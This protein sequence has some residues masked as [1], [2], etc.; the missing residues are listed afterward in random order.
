[1]K[2]KQV[3]WMAFAMIL[4][5]AY[6][7]FSLAQSQGGDSDEVIA[8]A[9]TQ[10][11]E[12]A[13]EIEEIVVTGSRLR[14]SSFTS[15]S[16]LQVISGNISR[17]AG[18]IDATS[19]LQETSAAAGQQTDLTFSRFVQDDGPG[20]TSLSLRG[21][22]AARTLILVNGRRIAPAGVE[23]A[24]VNPNLNFIP[25]TLISR[26]ELLLDG[27]SSVYGSDAV[28]GVTNAILRK[29]F[30]GFDV[31]IIHRENDHSAGP[32]TGLTLSWGQDW[33]RGFVGVGFE[34][35]EGAATTLDDVPWTRGCDRHHEITESGEIRT[36][37]LWWL[38]VFNMDVG[39][40]KVGALAGYVTANDGG[41]SLFYTPGYT[42]GGWGDFSDWHIR[43]GVSDGNG[44][45]MA[46]VNFR[47]YNLNGRTQHSN[48]S[49]DYDR[50]SFMAY[51]EYTFEGDTNLTLYSEL[52]YGQ[53]SSTFVLGYVQ[54]FPDV[55][56]NNPYN[57]CNPGATTG[58]G[59][60]CVQ[61]VV[62]SLEN[63]HV[64]R[65]LRPLLGG[66]DLTTTN[67]RG[68]KPTPTGDAM[69][70]TPV[71]VVRGDRETNETEVDQLRLVGGVRMDLPFM[72]VGSLSDWQLDVSFAY[73]QSSGESQRQ[74]IRSDRLDLALGTYST[75][76]TPCENNRTNDD[77]TPMHVL[78][79]DTAPGCVD[80]NMFAPS[81][82]ATIPGD[83]ATEAE[84]NYLLDIRDFDTEYTQIVFQT[85]ANGTL[86][87][88]PG[89]E[90]IGGIG[91]EWRNDD[92][93]SMP[94]HVARDGLIFGYFK[95]GGADGDKDTT[96]AYAEIELPLLGSRPL[97]E[98]LTLNASVRWTD[99][100]LYGDGTTYA[101]KL[102]YRPVSSLL[103]RGTTGTSF[104]APNLREV[105][106]RDQTGF[107]NLLDPCLIPSVALD[108]IT[109]DYI[110]ANDNRE[111]HV[112]ANCRANGVDPTRALNVGTSNVYSV[113]VAARGATNLDAEES[114]AYSVGFAWEQ[115]FTTAFD[116]ALGATYYN[117]EIENTIIEP[118]A[119]FLIFDCYGSLTGNSPFC[120]LITRDEDPVRPYLNLVRRDFLNRDEEKVSG[121]D[122][123][124]A[125]DDTWTIYG[126]P[127][128]I[129]IELN[130][131]H[132][133]GRSTLFTDDEGNPDFNQFAGEWGY[134]DWRGNM[135][136][137]ASWDN[138]Q[139]FWR[140]N[141]LSGMH[142]DPAGE[143]AFARVGTGGDTCL[144]PPNDEL[145]RDYSRSS[146]YFRHTASVTWQ[147]DDW[148]VRFGMDNVFDEGPPKVDS[149]EPPF[150]INGAVIGL[151]DVFGRTYFLDVQYK[152]GGTQ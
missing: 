15:I 54:L 122:V 22:G 26:Y 121:I 136:I 60:D 2:I 104:R 95:D 14:R 44:D 66:C 29:D 113:E 8:E 12:A 5:L 129:G 46:D 96:E 98:E 30:D 39:D 59:V 147:K 123:N 106:L 20:A 144:G 67:C 146:D 51:G 141:Y 43:S 120:G 64:A 133:K 35:R 27:A 57:L 25:G 137:R 47:D 126:R 10:Q 18:L 94:D 79:A 150:E 130:A 101:A 119:Q 48:L 37:D 36:R 84:S 78:A 4:G 108:D 56:A 72:N 111:A 97:A 49:P 6:T 142:Q 21:L 109:R 117:I 102:G 31:R 62:D 103:L 138:W 61:G 34:H 145:C 114:T 13:G 68:I 99:D 3:F 80:V 124:L 89:G 87:S 118:S 139:L 110:P 69:E 1:M 112:L 128:E 115:P 38:S 148:L 58:M 23:G 73:S 33:D 105:F 32:E 92:I 28:A 86:F 40:C 83:F 131:N 88:M 17:E 107:L 41:G 65:Q 116:L 135:T 132:V 42:N 127:I 143:D 53:A 152:F 140:A 90:V 85:F 125:Y 63:P 74:G 52:L 76:S 70:T 134:P 77:G 16:P 7:T 50:T 19:I 100:E 9:A 71:V 75:T 45:G 81:L 11:E 93:N 151:Y 91:L 55:P 82:Y 24:P 149:N